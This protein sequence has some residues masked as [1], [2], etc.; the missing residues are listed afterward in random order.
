MLTNHLHARAFWLPIFNALVAFG[1]GYMLGM[2]GDPVF[3]GAVCAALVWL[4]DHLRWMGV[5]ARAYAPEP[6]AA[7]DTWTEPEPVEPERYGIACHRDP[8]TTHI[9]NEDCP[10]SWDNLQHFAI[11]INSG[12]TLSTRAW[13]CTGDGMFTSHASYRKFLDWMWSMGYANA[14]LGQEA[15]LTDLGRC[16]LRDIALGDFRRVSPT[17]FLAQAQI[18]QFPDNSDLR[19]FRRAGEE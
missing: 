15:R 6:A 5:I 1:L 11:G 2:R 3:V 18:A 14:P 9:I 7:A 17:E 4:Y 19:P 8:S 10:L 13:V 16:M 12:Q